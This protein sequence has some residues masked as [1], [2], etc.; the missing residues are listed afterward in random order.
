M[1]KKAYAGVGGVARKV[2]N[3]YEG[4]NSVARTVKNGYVG[5]SGVA[6]QFF[7]SAPPSVLNDAT[8]AQI[9]AA[10]DAGTAANYWSVGDTKTITINGTV[11][12]TTFSNLSI[13]AFILGFDH[14]SSREGANKIHFG[15]GKISGKDVALVDSYVGS[16]TTV[17]GAFTMNTS[18]AANSNSGGWASSHMRKTV[19]G[20]DSTPTSPTANT[21][22]AALPSDLRTVM[23]SV[24][25]RTDN[26]GAASTASSA[27]TA[28]TDYL[29]L[30]A[31]FE[32]QGTRSYAN[33]YEQ[34]YQQQ[35]EYFKAGNSAVRYRHNATGTAAMWRLRSVRAGNGA[36]FCAVYASG[37]VNT[38]DQ[39]VSGGLAPAFAV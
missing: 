17:S 30:L 14:N 26:T 1:A 15:L 6:R 28:S 32:V 18:N 34:N 10:S 20:S 24:T 13:D 39:T 38:G 8:W 2:P 31:E 19:L 27:V 4:V 16:K 21:L 12:A 23:K 35:Y 3:I 29:W 33:Q 22:L 36:E 5:V 9:R 11:G 7:E 25:K 37:N